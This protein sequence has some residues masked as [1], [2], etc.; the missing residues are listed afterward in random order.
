MLRRLPQT[1]YVFARP[2]TRTAC[3]CVSI[4]SMATGLSTQAIT[5]TVP[6][7]TSQVLISISNALFN[8]IAQFFAPCFSLS[9]WAISSGNLCSAWRL[10]IPERY[11]L[12]GAN[13]PWNRVR[14]T[15]E[16][17]SDW[18]LAPAY[19]VTFAHNPK[20]EWTKQHLMSV[21]GKYKDFTAKDIMKVADRFG[22][23]EAKQLIADIKAT[24]KRWPTFAKKAG[25]DEAETRRIKKLHILL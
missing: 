10:M 21:N 13:T 11:W 14:F 20:G 23:G 22:V 3:K 9:V 5:F 7:Q 1:T 16:E 6:P 2:L 19:D 25:L 12:F 24:I 8:R 4:L 17:G 15:R 18:E